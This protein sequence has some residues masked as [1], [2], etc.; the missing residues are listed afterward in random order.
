MNTNKLSSTC[1]HLI[2]TMNPIKISF[3]RYTNK[4]IYILV[5]DKHADIWNLLKFISSVFILKD[6]S[7]I[8]RCERKKPHSKDNV[9]SDQNRLPRSTDLS[10]LAKW[11]RNTDGAIYTLDHMIF[12][13]WRAY[14]HSTT[15]VLCLDWKSISHVI[16]NAL[17]WSVVYYKPVFHVKTPN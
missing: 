5:P 12:S 6:V 14:V 11:A 9:T 17:K 8:H 15:L 4:I 7:S 13:H 1:H 10:G 3:L 16:Y 2:L